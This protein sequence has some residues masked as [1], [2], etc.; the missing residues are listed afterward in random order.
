MNYLDYVYDLNKIEDNYES[1]SVK[2]YIRKIASLLNKDSSK[3]ELTDSFMEL[4]LFVSNIE[5]G[6]YDR[7]YDNG[8]EDAKDEYECDCDYY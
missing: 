6:E 1:S 8:Y 5:A 3:E 4:L 2:A 7:G